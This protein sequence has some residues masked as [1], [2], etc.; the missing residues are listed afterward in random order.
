MKAFYEDRKYKSTSPV[1]ASFAQDMNFVAHWHKEIEVMYVLEGEL[2][3]GI[4]RDYRVLTAGEMYICGKNDIHYYNSEGLH[5]KAV[6]VIFDPAVVSA[7]ELGMD[8]VALCSAFLGAIH[9]AHDR[10]AVESLFVSAA[11]ERIAQNNM[12]IPLLK[13][14]LNEI[15][16]LVFR[17]DTDYRAMCTRKKERTSDKDLKPMQKALKYLEDNYTD[18]ITLDTISEYAGLS[19]FYFSRLFKTTTGTNFNTYVKQLRINNA[20]YLIKTTS[21]HIIDIA[22][23]AGFKS[24][25]T[26]NRTFMKIRGYTPQSVRK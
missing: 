13:L 19:P 15:F 3:V 23:Q 4:N 1:D 10:Q 21:E 6:M 22:Y 26:F 25:R 16:L 18:E 17:N 11:E 7:Q 24:I 5:S 12:Y 14:K 20:E 8:R 9:D 2:G